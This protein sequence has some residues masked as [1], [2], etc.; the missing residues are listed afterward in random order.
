[1]REVRTVGS[2]ECVVEDTRMGGR[3]LWEV[4]NFYGELMT[5]GIEKTQEVAWVISTNVALAYKRTMQ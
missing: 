4:R 3:Y 1:M 2:Y 5:A